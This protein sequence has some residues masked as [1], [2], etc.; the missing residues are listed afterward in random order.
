[1][2]AVSERSESVHRLRRK[3]S[4]THL[5]SS[6]ASN[7]V[8]AVKSLNGMIYYTGIEAIS[9]GNPGPIVVDNGN[10]L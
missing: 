4:F 3:L 2:V 6:T 9:I 8:Y 1:M 10:F 7:Q 5:R